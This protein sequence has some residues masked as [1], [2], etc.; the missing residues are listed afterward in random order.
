MLTIS[1]VSIILVTSAI[2]YSLCR[3]PSKTYR[4][5]NSKSI[6]FVHRDDVKHFGDLLLNGD[7]EGI[8]RIMQ[9]LQQ[10]EILEIIE[11]GDDIYLVNLNPA[12]VE[13]F[14]TVPR[15]LFVSDYNPIEDLLN[16]KAF[17]NSYRHISPE[18]DRYVTGHRPIP[19]YEFQ[20]ITSDLFMSDFDVLETLKY[21]SP[22]APFVPVSP[23][24]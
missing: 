17:N 13:N 20:E 23:L 24:L 10:R 3:I 4:H 11:M 19:V 14:R 8:H 7:V 12:S 15:G 9:I 21:L 2:F 16:L 22:Q 5:I 1:I 6:V 18:A